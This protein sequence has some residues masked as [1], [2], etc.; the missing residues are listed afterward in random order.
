MSTHSEH[1][2]PE[3]CE[4]EDPNSGQRYLMYRLPIAA[5]PCAPRIVY[6]CQSC[7]GRF[8]A[9][10]WTGGCPDC[11]GHGKRKRRRKRG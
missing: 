1:D 9:S 4:V 6:E 7:R 2:A 3:V 8:D 11:G 5:W 10:Q